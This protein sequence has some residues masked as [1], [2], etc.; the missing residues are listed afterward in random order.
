VDFD[1]R[2][3]V[4]DEG[5]KT[6]KRLLNGE[7]AGEA[8][9]QPWPNAVG[10]PPI[11]IG[12]WESGLWV[13]RAAREYDGWQASGRT[14]FRALTEGIKRFRDAGGRRALVAT[15]T[16]DLSKPEAKLNEDENFNLACGPESAK[17]R[18][19]RLAEMGYDDV[20]LV[21]QNH[22]EEDITEQDLRGYRALVPREP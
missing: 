20:L 1:S 12:V 18:L 11:Y 17:E 21:R 5:L 7:Q 14:T 13:K 4:F 6:I 16:I 10:G 22:T 15:V 8:N 2:F 9:L 3:K 19:H